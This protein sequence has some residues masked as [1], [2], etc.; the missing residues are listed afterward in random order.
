MRSI[1]VPMAFGEEESEAI[2]T[3]MQAGP[4]EGSGAG[5]AVER[6]ALLQRA[7]QG[8]DQRTEIVLGEFLPVAGAG[9]VT[10]APARA[11]PSGRL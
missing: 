4:T 6:R 10:R 11:L 3:A 8:L 1:G 9:G 2:R 5:P 7:A